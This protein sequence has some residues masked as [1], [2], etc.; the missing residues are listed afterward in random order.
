M[1]PHLGGRFSAEQQKVSDDSRS[2]DAAS[3]SKKWSEV[4]TCITASDQQG[5]TPMTAA[6]CDC[7]TGVVSRFLRSFSH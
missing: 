2:A 6:T 7:I 3:A 4:Y 5:A 1:L